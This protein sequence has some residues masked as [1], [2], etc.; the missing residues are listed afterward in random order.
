MY[1]TKISL[2][3]ANSSNFSITERRSHG[4]ETTMI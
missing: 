2:I 1:T 3:V 4:L